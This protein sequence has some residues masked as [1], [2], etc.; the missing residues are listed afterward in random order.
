MSFVVDRRLMWSG[1]AFVVS[2]I[3]SAA[4]PDLRG[5]LLAAGFLVA[6]GWASVLFKQLARKAP[7][8]ATRAK[9]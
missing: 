3:A 1:V 2:G 7:A 6:L 4:F 5:I 9:A 8:K